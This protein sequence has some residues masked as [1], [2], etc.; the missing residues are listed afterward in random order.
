MN[1]DQTFTQLVS[2]F[3]NNL[4]QN[5]L[6]Q[7]CTPA[8]SDFDIFS[9]LINASP[10]NDAVNYN[11]L[12]SPITST[13]D[14]LNIED[15]LTEYHPSPASTTISNF[16]D[17]LKHYFTNLP[18]IPE[19]NLLN[20]PVNPTVN[21]QDTIT[22][23]YAELAKLM[24]LAQ[25]GAVSSFTPSNLQQ[26]PAETQSSTLESVKI[27]SGSQS[28]THQ[29][30][31]PGC[32]RVFSRAYNLKTHVLTHNKNRPR[33]YR[34]DYLG[35]SKA[36]VR[37]ADLNRHKGIHNK[38]KV[39]NLNCLSCNKTFTRPDALARHKQTCSS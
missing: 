37:D 28:R 13:D 21:P 35:C 11:F 24:Q 18:P 22:L 3:N 30:H 29:C 5:E 8:N 34:C 12:S 14:V 23:T 31:Y 19:G 10:S 36:F 15:Y 2:S 38:V 6:Q 39:P 7:E 17:D 33:P 9:P 32:Q 27:R 4:Q 16:D 26:K 1:S 20:I 25:Q